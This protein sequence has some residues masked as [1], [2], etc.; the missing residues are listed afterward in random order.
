MV[1]I[2]GGGN[3]G[4]AGSKDAFDGTQLALYGVLT[5]HTAEIRYV[6]GNLDPVD[7]YDTID[8]EI[9]RAMKG[10]WIEFARTGVPRSPDGWSWPCY[11]STAPSITLNE[12]EIV[13]RPFVVTDLMA[14]IH[15]LRTET[16]Q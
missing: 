14:M 15:S 6:F 9:S 3:L 1:W 16:K 8:A 10:A 11:D 12:D 2:H 13:I 7:H 4:G 5:K